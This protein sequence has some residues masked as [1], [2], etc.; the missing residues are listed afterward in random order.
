MNEPS[1]MVLTAS[2]LIA[3]TLLGATAS[4][5]LLARLP[6]QPRRAVPWNGWDVLIVLGAYVLLFGTLALAARWGLGI[7]FD[8]GKRFAPAGAQAAGSTG[9]DRAG[10]GNSAQ[11]KHPSQQEKTAL[12]P[13]LVALGRRHQPGTLLLCGFMAVLVAPLSEEFFFRLLLQ[14]W[15][16]ALERRRRKRLRRLRWMLPG[17]LPVVVVSLLFASGHFRK[18][19]TLPEP[20]DILLAL[21]VLDGVARLLS[22]A[23]AVAYLR[24][25]R[26]ATAADLGWVPEKL[27]RDLALGLA[28]IACCL[29]LLLS[30]QAAVGIFLKRVAADPFTLFFFAIV[31][32][33]LYIR[34][35]RIVPS[36][37]MH[38]AFNGMML[39]AAWYLLK[40]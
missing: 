11:Q 10:G 7:R 17:L 39:A 13:L 8:V 6:W 14:G 26:R 5:T 34:T 36:I 32:G 31:A 9:A 38:V 37:A 1:V 35:H 20:V 21:T 23:F 19:E 29:P 18:E 15:L 25:Y 2:M 22:V 16:E 4:G 27:P 40:V 3:G 12:H 30:V 24:S 28:A 33:V